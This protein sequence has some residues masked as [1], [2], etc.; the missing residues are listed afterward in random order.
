MIP[1][2]TQTTSRLLLRTCSPADASEVC[3][4]HIRIWP[5]IAEWMPQVDPNYFTLA[6]HAERLD[7]EQ[8][9]HRQDRGL[10]LYL[11]LRADPE[12]QIIGDIHLA[13]IV[14]GAFQS[15]FLGYKMD[16]AHMCRGYMTEAVRHMV[17]YAF[18]HMQ[19]H[20]IEANI[21]PLNLAS[22]RVVEKCGFTLEG[23]S[24]KYLKINGV[25]EDHL[26][27]VVLNPAEE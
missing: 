11:S 6:A 2:I 12:Q 5:T 15:C 24:T 7:G 10:R 8:E 1:P 23:R 16:S 18:N 9:L 26:H 20:R 19:L 13:N 4:Y 21:M 3:A 27:Y 14:R 17:D 25:W 22:R